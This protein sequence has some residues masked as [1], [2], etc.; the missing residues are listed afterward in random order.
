MSLEV[1]IYLLVGVAIGLTID[2]ILTR[3]MGDEDER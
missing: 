2:G 3:F 1:C